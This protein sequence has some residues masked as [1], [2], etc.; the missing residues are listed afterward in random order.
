LE[1]IG[2][3]WILEKETK[4]WWFLVKYK[5]YLVEKG[6]TQRE[7]NIDFFDTQLPVTRIIL[8]RVLV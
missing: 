6:Y 2:C 5:G 1:T 8:K 3:I 7:K 4:T